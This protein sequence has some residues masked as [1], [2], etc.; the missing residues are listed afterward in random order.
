M[1][2]DPT[3]F[4]RDLQGMP[5]RQPVKFTVRHV[6]RMYHVRV[7]LADA[8]AFVKAIHRHHPPV[9]GHLFSLGAVKGDDLV[10]VAIIG[11]PVSRIRDDGLT[12]EVTRLCTDGTPNAC[13]FLYGAAARASF[14]LGFFKVGTYTLPDEGGASLRAAGWKLLGE[15]G[16][17]EWSSPSRPRK[18]AKHPTQPKMLWEKYP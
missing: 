9:V 16:G 8:N 2:T 13:S 11:R 15:R 12:A 4:R 14:A 17:G 6:G 7:S 5:D 18:P 1:Q 10:G 3:S